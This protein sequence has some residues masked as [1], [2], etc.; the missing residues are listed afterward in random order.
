LNLY[1]IK[2]NPKETD[3]ANVKIMFD[4][5]KNLNPSDATQEKIWAALAHTTFWNYIKYRKGSDFNSDKVRKIENNF[6]LSKIIEK[7]D[8]HT[9]IGKVMVDWISNI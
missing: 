8:F 9:S 2:K 5:L 3:F 4:A 1:V 7:I 6:S